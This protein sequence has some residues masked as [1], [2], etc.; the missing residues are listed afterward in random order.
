MRTTVSINDELL[1]AAK[2]R[3]RERG[4]SLGEV[5]DDALRRELAERPHAPAPPIPV[6]DGGTGMR[7]GIDPASNRSML[8]ALDVSG[9]LGVDR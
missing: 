1:F 3:A 5:L 7:P 2:D 4:V 8:E 9:E 6:F